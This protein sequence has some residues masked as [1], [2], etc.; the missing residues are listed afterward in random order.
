[1]NVGR[2]RSSPDGFIQATPDFIMRG[3]NISEQDQETILRNLERKGIVEVVFRGQPATRH[4][5]I[6]T[7]KIEELLRSASR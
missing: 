4:I 7:G 6:D 1:M 2:A 5:R 3:I